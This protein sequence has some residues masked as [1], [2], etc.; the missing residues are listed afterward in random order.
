MMDYTHGEVVEFK[1]NIFKGC[2]NHPRADDETNIPCE[3]I[4]HWDCGLE[5]LICSKCQLYT[6]IK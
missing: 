3:G 5:G 2:M 1:H 4:V 6:G